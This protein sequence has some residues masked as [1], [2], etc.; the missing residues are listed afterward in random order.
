M[1]G[2][3]M[4]NLGIVGSIIGTI[5]LIFGLS[6]YKN[7]KDAYKA[8]S[9]FGETESSKLWNGY[10]NNYKIFIIV[11][12]IILVIFL[13]L[14]IAGMINSNTKDTN[15]IYLKDKDNTSI[16]DKVGELKKMLDGN[17]ITQE[18]FELKKKEIIDKM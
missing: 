5:I 8:A 14:A 10:M 4:R 12:A 2:K 1:C 18:E 3:A 6:K 13:I 17:L 15:T 11:G 7:A 16:S 9:W